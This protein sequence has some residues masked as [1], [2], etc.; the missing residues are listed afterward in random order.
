MLELVLI[1]VTTRLAPRPTLSTSLRTRP[2]T[3]RPGRSASSIVRRLVQ[4]SN[5][6]SSHLVPRLSPQCSSPANSN[7]CARSTINRLPQASSSQ[8]LPSLSPRP[9][10]LSVN[11]TVS[12]VCLA[13]PRRPLNLA[14]TSTTTP[15]QSRPLQP[16]PSPSRSPSSPRR[17]RRSNPT[18]TVRL[19]LPA[20]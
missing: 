9:Q 2:T 19:A 15:A 8:R 10:Q 6:S 18:T 11:P 7:R 13:S 5:S 12:Q 4:Y 1:L 3:V 14:S 17:A 16:R 20:A